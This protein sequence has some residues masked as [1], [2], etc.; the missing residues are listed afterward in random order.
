MT[1]PLRLD[2]RVAYV[3]GSTRGIGNA[4]ART[5]AAH[6]ATVVVNGRASADTVARVAREIGDESGIEALGIHADQGVAEQAQ[7][8]FRTIFSE[9][10]RLDILVNNA[11]IIDD[12]LLGMISEQSIDRTFAVN[13]LAIVRNMQS[14]AKLM[15]RTGGGS[16]VNISSIVGTHG[17][18][19]EVVY[20]GSKAAV[21]GMTKS[22]A[23]ELAPQGV[24]VNAIAPGF[25]DTD[26]TRSLPESVRED[27][28]GRIG[29]GRAG[30]P[31]DVANVALFLAGDL[32][33]HVTGQV[34]G[35]DGSLVV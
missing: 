15:R 24:R 7:G 17:N 11:G 16:I 4:T 5:L 32:S 2:G 14:A 34:I 12:A 26:L 9:L 22:A 18:A 29:S 6:G 30:T 1:S 25:I 8:A 28:K 20:G 13:A 27:W 3:T 35:V 21:I 23:K 19:G 10:G 33:D 31:Q